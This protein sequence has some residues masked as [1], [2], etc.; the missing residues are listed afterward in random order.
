[1]ND[2]FKFRVWNK[3]AKEMIASFNVEDSRLNSY[4]S[5]RFIL[6]QCVGLKDKNGQL[7]YEGDLLCDASIENPTKEQ[8]VKVIYHLGAFMKEGIA[9]D[10]SIWRARFDEIDSQCWRICGNLYENSKLLKQ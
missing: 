3:Q 4:D 7:I 9:D 2:R 5:D 1:M 6:M 10:V 8:V